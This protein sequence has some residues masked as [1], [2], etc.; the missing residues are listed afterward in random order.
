MKLLW[1]Q[2]KTIPNYSLNFTKL[3]TILENHLNG[4][5]YVKYNLAQVCICNRLIHGNA[6]YRQNTLTIWNV[7]NTH[8]LKIY[9]LIILFLFLLY[10]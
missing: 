1:S 10:I 2:D 7:S 5:T 9:F 8:I 3:F 6:R 4:S